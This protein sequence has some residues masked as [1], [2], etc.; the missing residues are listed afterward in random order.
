MKALPDGFM[1]PGN[2]LHLPLIRFH[3]AGGCWDRTQDSCD[4]DIGC[5]M[6]KPLGKI[7]SA[8]SARSHPHSARSHPKSARSLPRS[9]RYHQQTRQG[10]IHIRLDVIQSRLDLI[11]T[12]LDLIHARLDLIN[13]KFE[14]FYAERSGDTYGGWE[15]K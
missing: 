2:Y 5:Q 11:S 13:K 12:L 4:F 1:P 14:I 7:S 3:C 8:N 15:V 6:L 10:L 9:A